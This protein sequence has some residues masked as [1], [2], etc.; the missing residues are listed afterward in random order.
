MYPGNFRRTQPAYYAFPASYPAPTPNF[1][2]PTYVQPET[3]TMSNTKKLTIFFVI[4]FIISSVVI[5]SFAS[6]GSSS[7]HNPDDSKDDG[8]RYDTYRER[9]AP[10]YQDRDSQDYR[11]RY[12]YEYS[13]PNPFPSTPKPPKPKPQQETPP[14]KPMKLDED[15]GIYLEEEENSH[16]PTT[17]NDVEISG[18]SDEDPFIIMSSIKKI[19]EEIKLY[20]RDHGSFLPN[21]IAQ[22]ST[23]IEKF[24]KNLNNSNDPIIVSR[25]LKPI[26]SEDLDLACLIMSA[27]QPGLGT[28]QLTSLLRNHAS[29]LVLY[30]SKLFVYSKAKMNLLNLRG[31]S[32]WKGNSEIKEL[33]MSCIDPLLYSISLE[34]N[35]STSLFAFTAF[36]SRVYLDLTPKNSKD[37]YRGVLDF[38]CQLSRQS[39]SIRY[40]ALDTLI[41]LQFIDIAF[42]CLVLVSLY[43][44]SFEVEKIYKDYLDQKN[45]K[46][47]SLQAKKK[48]ES[49]EKRDDIPRISEL[50]NDFNNLLYK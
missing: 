12:Q 31:R 19:Y 32:F 13:R 43:E 37:F 29:Y 27:M 16:I 34:F 44:P 25:L 18:L 23:K 14:E 24:Y 21:H 46:E 26:K 7:R 33:A 3:A 39:K 20:L 35:D 47:L 36:L 38:E 9:S 2:P 10:R 40:C 49:L 28:A 5:I 4:L 22:L 11:P 50:I 45:L 17:K 6:R 8:D 48:L 1:R 30:R 41:N 15:F 42:K